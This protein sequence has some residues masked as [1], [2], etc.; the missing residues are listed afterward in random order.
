[1]GGV[2]KGQA[3]ARPLF[4]GR[5]GEGRLS[6]E[7][8]G[9]EIPR[10]SAPGPRSLLLPATYPLPRSQPS[11]PLGGA[12]TNRLQLTAAPASPLPKRPRPGD[13]G[14]EDTPPQEA[15]IPACVPHPVPRPLG[16]GGGAIEAPSFSLEGRWR[17]GRGA[18]GCLRGGVWRCD[19][20]EADEPAG[21]VEGGC[22]VPPGSLN[23][24]PAAATQ[25]R[26][27]SA[28]CGP[29]SPAPSARPSPDGKSR[30]P[31]TEWSETQ[32]RL[33][34][35]RPTRWRMRS[36]SGFLLCVKDTVGSQEPGL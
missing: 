7:T 32:A 6:R 20:G 1:M 9:V 11:V 24:V 35:A 27:R 10:S 29:H 19:P 31:G 5:G 22:G 21:T 3:L 13:A 23:P 30:S 17:R 25:R 16:R 12:A 15:E 2:E 26:L 34:G 4:L 36:K 8:R 33:L 14:R 18:R 28:E